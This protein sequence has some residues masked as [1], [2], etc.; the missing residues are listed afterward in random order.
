M[1]FQ[2]EKYS[3]ICVKKTAVYYPFN[4]STKRTYKFWKEA[5]CILTSEHTI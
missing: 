3:C 2:K 4:L 1:V 5:S